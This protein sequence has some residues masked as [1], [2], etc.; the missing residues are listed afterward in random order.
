MINPV[1]FYG[2]S[3]E[4]YKYLKDIKVLGRNCSYSTQRSH[5]AQRDI[6]WGFTL[7]TWY[8]VWAGSGHLEQRG[9]GK[10][11]YAMA[12]KGDVGPYTPENVEIILFTQNLSDGH[13]NGR[14]TKKRGVK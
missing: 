7:K 2:I 11:K 5:A 4:L 14:H 3:K 13:T 8:Q 10:G 9:R 1:E 12:R 6:P